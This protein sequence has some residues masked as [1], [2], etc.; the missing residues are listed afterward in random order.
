MLRVSYDTSLKRIAKLQGS[1][2][3]LQDEIAA[4]QAEAESHVRQGHHDAQ[5]K[6]NACAYLA[7]MVQHIADKLNQKQQMVLRYSEYL[8][9]VRDFQV[10]RKLGKGSFAAVYLA[11]MRDTRQVVAMKVLSKRAVRECN[12]HEQIMKERTALVMASR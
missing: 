9:G 5:R 1:V 12:L 10:L 11:R 8:V 2:T 6:V 7:R 3:N 4:H